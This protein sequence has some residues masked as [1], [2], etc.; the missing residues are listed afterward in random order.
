V[1]VVLVLLLV[2][3][4]ARAQ[5]Q[6]PATMDKLRLYLDCNSCDH[7]YV[8]TEINWVDY[9]VDRQVSDVHI[10]VT[11]QQTG[12]GGVA[13]TL[14]FMGRGGFESKSDTLHYTASVDDTQD[15][16][17]QGLVRVLKMGLMRYMV[18]SPLAPHVQ[19]AV[20][21]PAAQAG[22]VTAPTQD[23]WNYWTFS[24]SANG[25]LQGESRQ[26]FNSTYLSLSANRTTEA[27]K[28][29]FGVGG[30]YSESNFD[31]DSVRTITSIRRSYNGSALIAKSLGPRLSAGMQLEVES[32]TFENVD[33]SYRLAPAIEYNIFPYDQSTRRSFTFTYSAGFNSFD[34]TEETLFGEVKETRPAH[35]LSA[36]YSTRQPWGQTNL[37]VS[38]SQF[39]HDTSKYRWSTSTSANVRLIRGLSLQVGGFYSRVHDQLTLPAGDATPEEILLRQR[40]LQTNYFF[41]VNFGLSYRFGSIF[42]TVV[43]P[44]FAQGIGGGG[45]EIFF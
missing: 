25:Y 5:G 34:Y 18:S 19:I 36:Y 39:L 10:L 13:Y 45:M 40:Q 22:S 14:F 2:P 29:R 21:P 20:T 7:N 17:R 33:I 16:R 28:I 4:A 41:G 26:D 35:A 44:R 24:I 1:T 11:T 23:P 3:A 37:G 43:N 9:V 38:A 30:N 6:A 32:N 12:P 27:W 42:S 8:K 15:V 31:V